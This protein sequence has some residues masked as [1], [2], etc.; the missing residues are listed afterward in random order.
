MSTQH[1]HRAPAEESSAAAEVEAYFRKAEAGGAQPRWRN[2]TG[3]CQ[4]DIE[5]AGIWRATI[6][7][8]VVTVTKGESDDTPPRCVIS[9]SAEDFLRLVRRNTNLNVFAAALQELITISG[10]LAFAWAVLGG[11]IM[12]PSEVPMR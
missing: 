7:K 4:F 9:C 11:F 8:G 3:V 1:V 10:D 2:L 12:N 6:K 5:G